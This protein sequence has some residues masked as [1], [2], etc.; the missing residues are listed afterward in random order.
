M[1][2]LIDRCREDGVL[3]IQAGANTLRFAPPLIVTRE[4]LDEGLAVVERQLRT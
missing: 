2:D 1:A 3:V 4:Q